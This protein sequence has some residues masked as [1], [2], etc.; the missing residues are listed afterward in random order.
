M[1]APMRVPTAIYISRVDSTYA[2]P[3][4]RRY[5]VKRT[6]APVA[7]A[8]DQ[9]RV[10]L[11]FPCGHPIRHMYIPHTQAQLLEEFAAGA[12]LGPHENI[13]T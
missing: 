6:S 10:D 2:Y 7:S 13:L 1:H 4:A 9:A 3:N 8:A 5:A 12:A 11:H